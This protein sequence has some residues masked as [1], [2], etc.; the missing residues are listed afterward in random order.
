MKSKIVAAALAAAFTVPAQAATTVLTFNTG[1][2]ACTTVDGGP[3]NQACTANQQFIGGNY[4]ST[5]ALAVSYNAS[6]P[7][8]SRTSL[9][10]NTFGGGLATSF[11]QGPEASEIYFTPGAGFEVSFLSFDWRRLTATSSANFNFRVLDPMGNE[12]FN[13]GNQN[14]DPVVRGGTYTPNTAYFSGPLTFAFTNGARGAVG[15]DNIAFDVRAMVTSPGAV[16][17]PA[18]WA[19]M[20]GGFGMVGGMMRRG[21]K[22][23]NIALA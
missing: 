4:G 10:F 9:H 21:R 16:P 3:A 22:R 1:E 7:S 5:A 13:A 20:I 14:F 11:P 23:M 15:V 17:E 18:T 8:G 2:L 19:M 12:L 6:E